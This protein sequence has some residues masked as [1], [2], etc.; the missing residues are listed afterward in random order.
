M[1]KTRMTEWQ[2]QVFLP[3]TVSS[4][5]HKSANQP[6][7]LYKIM[8]LE[9]K[10]NVSL[11]LLVHWVAESQCHAGYSVHCLMSIPILTCQSWHSFYEGTSVLFRMGHVPQSCPSLQHP[12]HGTSGH[13]SKCGVVFSPAWGLWE[14]QLKTGLRLFPVPRHGESLKHGYPSWPRCEQS[15]DRCVWG[16]LTCGL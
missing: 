14:R 4:W 8:Q 7:I 16:S 6:I 15:P 10:K 9:E 13:R 5:S 2:M 12:Q 11:L 1:N 3:Y